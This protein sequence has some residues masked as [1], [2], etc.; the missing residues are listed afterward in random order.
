VTK[1]LDIWPALPIVVHHRPYRKGKLDNLIA[2]I[3][4]N[5]RVCNIDFRAFFDTSQLEEV[6]S[7]MQVPFPALTDLK[8]VS[9][10]AFETVTVIPDSFLGGSAPRLQRLHLEGISFPGLPKL[11]LSATDLVSLQLHLPHSGY[12]SPDAMVTCLSALVRLKSFTLEFESR[13]SRQDRESRHLPPPTRT[14][15]PALTLLRFKGVRE[16][17]EDLMTWIDAPLLHRLRIAF[18]NE[19]VPNIPRLSHFINRIPKFQAL[20]EARVIFS[21]S[22]VR[23]AFPLPIQTIGYEA[24]VLGILWDESVG[25]LSSLAR[26]CRSLLPTLAKVE[27]LHIYG[28]G[29]LRP[30]HWSGAIQHSHWL[31]LL[32][33]FTGAK[34]LY[35][36]EDLAPCISPL[37]RQLVGERT[38]EVLPAVQ[39]L[40]LYEYQQQQRR[41]V[42]EGIKN[43][44]APH[45]LSEHPIAVW[46]I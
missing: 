40:F 34:D 35:L 7:V 43:F 18:F 16:Y 19:P 9:N 11:L 12:I 29:S 25:Q 2:A 5:D 31:E 4:H 45:Q 10:E 39:N 3:K 32:H 24:L 36:S 6:V 41:P 46:S 1:K 17:A 21:D 27:R 13:Q 37:L 23:A 38:T 28:E 26:L 15:L 20:D 42:E 14:L 30:L 22:G 8:L 44:V 33:L